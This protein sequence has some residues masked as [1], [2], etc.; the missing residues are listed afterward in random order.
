MVLASTV[1]LGWKFSGT[2]GNILLSTDSQCLEICC[3]PQWTF[4]L[5]VQFCWRWNYTFYL[6]T[7]FVSSSWLWVKTML[8]W[9]E[10]CTL[11]MELPDAFKTWKPRAS[12]EN[13]AFTPCATC[14]SRRAFRHIISATLSAIPLI[15]LIKTKITPCFMVRLV[16]LPESSVKLIIVYRGQRCQGA[17]I[18]R[19]W[20]NKRSQSTKLDSGL[21]F[22]ILYNDGQILN[23]YFGK[24]T[25]RK[26]T[27]MK[28]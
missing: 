25:L 26:E 7:L 8:Y 23:L 11:A 28:T 16:Q 13:I 27:T 19:P 18:H 2:H 22:K 3:N 12:S 6:F 20:F 9:W 5:E 10:I 1:I 14:I 15:Y 17:W 4:G 21:Q 24:K